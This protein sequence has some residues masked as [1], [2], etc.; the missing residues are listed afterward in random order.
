MSYSKETDSRM[1]RLELGEDSGG[2]RYF[3]DG[4]PVHAGAILELLLPGELW[5][6]VR[7][8]WTGCASDP[9]V[10]FLSLAETNEQAR[11]RLPRGAALRWAKRILP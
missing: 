1:S 3:L 2:P 10:F 5:L 8:E 6:P 7:F 11:V 9:P 4:R